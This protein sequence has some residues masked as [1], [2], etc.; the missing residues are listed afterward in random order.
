MNIIKKVEKDKKRT[1]KQSENF[2]NKYHIY[3]K[4]S[5]TFEVADDCYLNCRLVTVKGQSYVVPRYINR[6]DI[7]VENKQGTHGWQLRYKSISIFYNDKKSNSIRIGL[8]RA[9]KDLKKGFVVKAYLPLGNQ[10]MLKK[11]YKTKKIKLIPGVRISYMVT[12]KKPYKQYSVIC[13]ISVLNGKA[14]SFRKYIAVEKQLTQEKINHAITIAAT[15][16]KYAEHLFN[17]GD[18]DIA[19]IIKLEHITPK[20]IDEYFPKIKFPTPDT[21]KKFY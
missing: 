18:S 12:K 3:E 17:S 10:V 9:K 15:M 2:K 4:T 1:R 6:V 20:L 21:I 5:I 16:R 11:A 13:D 7:S 14:R 8:E 19:K